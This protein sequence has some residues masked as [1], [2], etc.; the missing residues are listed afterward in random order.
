M[1]ARRGGRGAHAGRRGRAW[2]C[3][4]K[5]AREVLRDP[6]LPWDLAPRPPGQLAP[7][8]AGLLGPA[9][10]WGGRDDPCPVGDGKRA[11]ESPRWAQHSSGRSPR[12]SSG[13]SSLLTLG[14][15]RRRSEPRRLGGPGACNTGRRGGGR[16][17]PGL[18]AGAARWVLGHSGAGKLFP[19][20]PSG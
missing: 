3:G 11:G 6:A 18:G 17:Q 1:L 20:M 8:G 16:W 12:A 9:R 7:A 15:E 5:T 13:R 4:G 14:W 10:L 2:R 19:E